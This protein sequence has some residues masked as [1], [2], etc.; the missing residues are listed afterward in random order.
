M[1]RN[2][3]IFSKDTV[4][5]IWML[6][7]FAG[8]VVCLFALFFAACAKQPENT[9]SAFPSANSDFFTRAGDAAESEESFANASAASGETGTVSGDGTGAGT[10]TQTAAVEEP[11]P[12]RLA[13]S[14]DMG[15]AYLDQMI[16]LGDST[17][18][19][20]GYY[21]ERGYYDLVP[22][23]QV[24][25]PASG[26]LTLAYY[27]VATVVY[28]ETGEEISIRE[29]VERAK[30]EYLVITLGVNGISF[31]NET[32]FISTY[33]S[34]VKLIQEA[35]PDTKIIL[36]SMYPVTADYPYLNDINND[37]INAGNH[38]IERVAADTG[39][40]F[41][42]SF[43]SVVGLDGNL[44]ALNCNGDGIHLSGEGFTEVMKYVRTH[45]YK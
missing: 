19:G 41:L 39:V 3:M 28:P 12:T 17:T 6:C 25:T 23:S 42:Y 44:T 15:R 18:Y 37:K 27:D 38:W 36:N 34:L 45:A 1:K 13:L 2:R 21:Y 26:T 30:P 4:N 43:E 16:F 9:S 7:L 33:T 5:R 32:D 29:A 8:A 20:L 22:P 10:G 24:W 31:M 11:T 40:R 35:S 14:D